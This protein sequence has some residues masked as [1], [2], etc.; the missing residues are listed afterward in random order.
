MQPPQQKPLPIYLRYPHWFAYT[1]LAVVILISD[2]VTIASKYPFLRYYD[3]A[4][5]PWEPYVLEFSSSILVLTAVP[6]LVAFDR[7][8]PISWDTWRINL[9]RH[10]VATVVFAAYKLAG[11]LVLRKLGYAAFGSHYDFNMSIL[12]AHFPARTVVATEYLPDAQA[13]VE[14]L[15]LSYAYRFILLQLYGEARE[16]TKPEAGAPVE[17]LERPQRFLVRKLGKE[18]L[19]AVDDIEHLEAQGNYV[20]LHVRGHAYPLRSTMSAIG[21]KLDPTK[22]VRTHRSH[23]VNLNFLAEIHPLDAGDASLILRDGTPVPCSRNYRASLRERAG[24]E[25]VSTSADRQKFSYRTDVS[26]Q[27]P[28]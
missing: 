12:G 21:S 17:S 10:A 3:R 25:P 19:V 6:L 11:E 15:G 26:I 27:A 2:L 7:R 5:L 9:L 24:R 28:D 22:F 16:F 4:L 20:N 13:Y 23:I 1:L 8:L 14:L 18:F